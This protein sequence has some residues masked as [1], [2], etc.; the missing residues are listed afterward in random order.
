[1]DHITEFQSPNFHGTLPFRYLLYLTIGLFAVSTVRVDIIELALVLLFAH[2]ALYSARY[3]PLFA[4]IV[5]PILVR[6]GQLLLENTQGRIISFLR[7]RIENIALVDAS[8]HGH[9]WITGSL[10]LVCAGILTGRIYFQFDEKVSPV[11]AIEFLKKEALPGNMFNNE[12][13]GDSLIYA[14]W[15]QYR[16]F[17]DGRSDM[18]GS[19]MREYIDVVFL[20]PNW[21]NILAKYKINWILETA[22][23]PL[24]VLLSQGKDWQLIYADRFAHIYLLNKVSENQAILRKFSDVKT[25]PPDKNG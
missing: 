6:R 23:S 11:T 12:T 8:L 13:F 19:L 17:I 5:C 21:K 22:D 1:M 18:Y 14:A 25:L 15:P 10:V 3:I 16:V 2:M 24:S 20:A 4:I 9:L 7:K